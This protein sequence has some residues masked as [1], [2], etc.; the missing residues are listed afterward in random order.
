[1]KCWGYNTFGQLGNGSKT[2]SFIPVDVTGIGSN[3]TRLSAGDNHTCVLTCEGGVKCWGINGHGE[4]GNESQADSSVPVSPF[5]LTSGV[6]EIS[7]GFNH[8]CAI[9]LEGKVK[10]WGDNSFGQLGN[11]TN[12]S[13]KIPVE[14]MG[15]GVK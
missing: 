12:I 1:V 4:L 6:S 7:A 8:T 2:D 15:T 14:V 3:V 11:G 9:T 10:C 13:S 5:G